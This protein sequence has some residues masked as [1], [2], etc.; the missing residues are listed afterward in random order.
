MS[1]IIIP[2]KKI[3]LALIVLC[4]LS[5]CG[6]P[7]SGFETTADAVFPPRPAIPADGGRLF[8]WR[9]V[10]GL[11]ATYFG[12]YNATIS[13]TQCI[14]EATPGSKKTVWSLTATTDEGI[15]IGYLGVIVEYKNENNSTVKEIIPAFD[16][17]KAAD[18]LYVGVDDGFS[19]D[20]NGQLA[21][22]RPVAHIIEIRKNVI[23][24]YDYPIRLVPE[25]PT[26]LTPAP[27]SEYGAQ[28]RG[29]PIVVGP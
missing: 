13:A 15:G 3:I 8:R 17:S 2:L 16:L 22:I 6:S 11:M 28:T 4:V 10:S 21:S 9:A 24:P 14:I 12:K 29:T 18:G 1:N 26:D 27:E 25:T 19:F 20:E 7:Y 5:G 23:R